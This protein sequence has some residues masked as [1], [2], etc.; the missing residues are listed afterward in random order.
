MLRFTSLTIEDFG[1]FKGIQT[2]DFTGEDGV[3]FIWGNNGRGKTT[4]LNIFRYA[5]YGKFQNRR[6]AVVD[7]TAL[8]NIE[9]HAEGRYGF[10]VVLRMINDD[11]QYELTRQFKVRSGIAKPTKNDDYDLS[12]FLKE[13][14]SILSGAASEHILKI[15]MPEQ[16]ARFF[17]FDGE[18]LQEY[19]ELLLEETNVGAKI[20]DSIEKI[21]GVPVLTNGVTDAERVLDE[22]RKSKT[23]VAQSNNLTQQIA[24]QIA[25]L[26]VELQEHTSEI[27]RL[28]DELSQEQAAK[29]RLEGDFQQSEHIKG[30]LDNMK[31]LEES[32]GEKKVRRANLLFQIVAITRDV[33]KDVVSTKVSSILSDVQGQVKVLDDKENAQRTAKNFM[34]DMRIAAG[35]KHCHIC[36]QDID[37]NLI[38]K[39]EAKIRDAESKYGGLSADE[40]ILLRSLQNRRVI[41]ESMQF[42]SS[43]GKLE[44]LEQQLSRVGVE[45]SDSERKL[46]VLKEELERYGD[47]EELSSVMQTRVKELAQCMQK[48]QN[49]EDGKKQ[50]NSKIASTRNALVTLETKLDKMANDTEMTIAKR[51]VELCEQIHAIFEEGVASYRDKLKGDVERDATALFLKV[52]NDPDYIKLAINENYG[53][54][55]IHASGEEVPLRSAGFEHVVALS[56]IGALHK[57]APLRGPIIMDSPFG[58]LDPAHKENITRALPDMSEQ[59]V[60]LAYTHEI[61]EQ[62]ARETLGSALKKEYR[63]A[64]QSSFYTQ[65]EAQMD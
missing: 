54:S 5:L 52:S 56:L 40:V 53:L 2:I 26:E 22:Y 59:I 50:E 32:I 27:E 60:L 28:R 19:E 20:K 29:N 14:G 65:I 49:L 3:T 17:L 34:N 44:V 30:L 8:S 42:P 55:M 37:N 47:I 36:D 25:A 58:R 45:I 39:M 61:D 1:P 10:K 31:S 64:R 48:I 13:D 6:G 11:K 12:V 51:K 21:L 35:K 16:V 63:L 43:K 24:S 23:R 38:T 18:L 46:K 57:N 62:R 15:I 33:W 7:L 9:S 41:L 4:L